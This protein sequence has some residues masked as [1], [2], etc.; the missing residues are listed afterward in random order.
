MNG[1]TQAERVGQEIVR[2]RHAGLDS[3]TFRVEAV[4][5]LWK[6]IP[7]DASFFATADPATLLF[8][9]AVP[10]ASNGT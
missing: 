8:T 3:R 9:G 10:Y 5:R 4:R 1:G 2:L 6:A 7:V